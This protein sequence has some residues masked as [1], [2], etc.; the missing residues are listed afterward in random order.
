V[1][2]FTLIR[3][4]KIA[5]NSV[6]YSLMNTTR[7][8]LFLP[9]SRD[10]KYE[11][12]TAID[13]FFWRVG[14]LIQAGVVFVGLNWL[15]WGVQQFAL[16][17]LLLA[18]VWIVLAVEIGRQFAV[19]A[20]EN[21][22]NVAP[23]AG[24]PIPDLSYQPGRPVAHVVPADAFRDADPGDVLHLAARLA[25]G[26]PLPPWLR[27]EPRSRRFTG[28]PPDDVAEEITVLVVASDV[29]GFEASSSFTLRVATRSG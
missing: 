14:D 5:E 22:T 13:S 7:H 29:D 11:G 16:L 20:R 17:S 28:L 2:V 9:V 6:D 4:V 8:A 12:K 1:P 21:V 23:E 3:L 19:K 18:T 26:R 10:A 15:G 25:D 27:F 24:A